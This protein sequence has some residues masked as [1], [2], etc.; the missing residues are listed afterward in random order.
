MIHGQTDIKFGVRYV[1][2]TEL[3]E[4]KCLILIVSNTACERF[5]QI[6]IYNLQV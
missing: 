2:T 3:H 4:L 6:K 1:E 5:L